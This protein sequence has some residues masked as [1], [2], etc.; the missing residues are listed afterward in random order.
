[1]DCNGFNHMIQYIMFSEMPDKLRSKRIKMILTYV[2]FLALAGTA[3]ALRSQL[4]ETVDNLRDANP[5]PILLILPLVIINHFSQ[6]KLYQGVFRI[7]GDRFRT[8]SMMRL[9]LELNLVNNIFPSGGVSGF[10]YL[11][12]RM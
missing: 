1:M 4:S 12:I 7:F 5:W 9:S 6:A 11:S 8:K 2:T 3:Y 10:S